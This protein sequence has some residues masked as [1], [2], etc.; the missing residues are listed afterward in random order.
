VVDRLVTKAGLEARYADSLQTALHL[1]D[2]I[3]VAEWA[4]AN[5]DAKE[6]PRRLIFSEKFACPVSGFTISEIEPR[7]FSFNNPFGACPVCDGLGV[8]LAFDAD[9]IVTDRDKTLHKGAVT[10]WAKS[11]SPFYTQTLQALSRHYGFSMDKPW[12]ELP[13][14]AHEV[15]L[16]GTGAEK[17]KF[18]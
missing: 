2:G 12:R 10:P 6:D 4:T 14:K 8:K 3:A 7:L 1:A 5:A 9:L 18:S 11:P 16:H 17:I 13:A 15:I